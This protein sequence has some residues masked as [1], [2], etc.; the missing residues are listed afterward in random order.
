M[1]TLI[2][3]I[4]I[5]SSQIYSQWQ[6]DTRLTNNAA[7]SYTTANN[8]WGIAAIGNIVYAVWYDNRDGNDEIY[9]KRST[10]A[11]VTWG[12]DTRLTNNSAASQFPSVAVYSTTVHVVWQ[13]ER[14]GNKEIYY[15]RSTDAGLTWGTDIRLTNQIDISRNPSLSVYTSNVFVVWDDFRHGNFEIFCKRSTDGGVTWGFDIRL[16]NNAA[17]SFNPSISVS[18]SNVHVAWWDERD[19]NPE[20]Y[21]KHSSDNGASW[22]PDN[23]LTNNPAYSFEPSVSTS[24]STVHVVWRENR[25]GN[26]EIYYMVSTNS[27]A[28]WI[29]ETRLTYSSARSDNPSISVAGSFVHVVWKDIRDGNNEIYYK[30]STNAGV[31]WESE[32]RLTNNSA[33]SENPSVFVYSSAVHI[34]WNDNRDGNNEIFYKRNPIG[35]TVGIN[36]N[37]SEIPKE[38]SLSQNYPNPFNPVTNIKFDLPKSSNVMLKV[39]NAEGREVTTLANEYLQAGSYTADFDGTHFASGLYFYSIT[40]GDFVQTK[41]MMMVK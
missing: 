31:S 22:A 2:I 20:I 6:P 41:K 24:G 15:K 28:S 8:A 35:S 37:N 16:T 14:D 29:W 27:G 25:D 23:R 30:R 11:G 21:Y 13:E 3:A 1:K 34:V 17:G 36:N 40:A 18:G 4:L 26:D 10:D 32:L 5:I 7:G 33:S 9:Y 38:F 19:S 39:Y 12:T